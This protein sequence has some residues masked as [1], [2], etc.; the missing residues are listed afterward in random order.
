MAQRYE[1]AWSGITNVCEGV[2]GGVNFPEKAA[3]EYHFN[4][5]QFEW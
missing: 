5:P 1:G 4:C 3:T 2:G